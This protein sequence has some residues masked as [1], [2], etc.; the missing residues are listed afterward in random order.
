MSLLKKADSD[1]QDKKRKVLDVEVDGSVSQLFKNN[2]IN[3][4][5]YLKSNDSLIYDNFFLEST[6]EN[7]IFVINDVDMNKVGTLHPVLSQIKMNDESKR[8][9]NSEKSDG[10]KKDKKSKKKKD[11]GSVKEFNKNTLNNLLGYAISISSTSIEDNIG[12]KDTCI[13][14][15]K[16]QR[17][18]KIAKG[19][20]GILSR[21][22]KT[23]KFS[24]VDGDVFKCDDI[25]DAIYYERQ[26]LSGSDETNIKIMFVENKNNFEEI[27]SFDNFYM[28]RAA[29]VYTKLRSY[30]NIKIEES[31]Y[32]KFTSNKRNLKKICALDEENV[33]ADIDF[34]NILN[35]VK[36][37]NNKEFDVN[38][39]IDG[40]N[41]VIRDDESFDI[42]TYLCRKKVM[43]VLPEGDIC[44][45]DKSKTLPKKRNKF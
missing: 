32:N 22:W 38:L 5:S 42:F 18:S 14:F 31:F 7:T 13:Y 23:G 37:A 33:F 8:S 3:K 45:V 43:E 19:K 28:K 6:N 15:R 11:S 30:P 20:L 25:I 1:D 41:I 40:E 9:E 35:V 12:I 39:A 24:K 16:Y 44:F 10:G 27:F 36:A 4:C 26:C 17:G 29:Q 34:S 21:D 2:F